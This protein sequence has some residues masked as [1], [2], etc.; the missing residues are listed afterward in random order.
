MG[1]RTDWPTFGATLVVLLGICIP[2][3]VMQEQAN[4]FINAAFSVMT[5]NFG[6]LYQW[7]GI[8]AVGLLLWLAL[9]RFGQVKL[10]NSC[11][12]PE[13]SSFSWAGMLFCAGIGSGI[14]YWGT[15]EWAYYLQTPPLGI[16]ANTD[17]AA[18][19]AA[20]YGMFHWGITAWAFYGVPAIPLAYLY[21]VRKQ[22]ELKLSAAC[23][24]VLGKYAH[25]A[26]GKVIDILFM[27]GLLGGVGT[28]LGL[29]TPMVAAGLSEVFG[30]EN[31]FGLSI[32]V[33]LLCTAIFGV[34]AYSGLKKGIKILS[35]INVWLAI[36]LI[37]FILLV[38]PTLF[39]LK[40]TT[41]SIGLMLQNF[42]QMNFWTDPITNSGF[43]ESWT[44]FYWAWWIAYGPFMGLFVAKISRGRTIRQ[45]ITGMLVY[46][47]LGCWAYFGV[48]GNYAMHLELNDILSVTSILN[49][50]DAPTAI[51]AVIKSLP[52]SSLVL[53][54]FCVLAL[55]FLATQFDSAAYIMAAVATVKLTENEHPARWHVLFWALALAALPLSLMFV[56]GL[57]A[58]QTAA[59]TLALPQLFITAIM[60]ISLVRWLRHDEIN[61]VPSAS[62]VADTSQSFTAANVTATP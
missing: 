4:D 13:F 8:A 45:V 60:A 7:G 19:W 25:G 40:T 58:L 53:P 26:L 6:I 1:V 28:S 14:L 57:K 62:R 41:N 3:L 36:A 50:K 33:M 11:E 30:I 55:I 61:G 47:S 43:T 34:S 29:G 2:L 35:D 54:L 16:T 20:T 24:G 49:E 52:L 56:G 17:K 51:I 15:I 18:E 44:V 39:I 22:P 48:L 21:H 59:I 32:F 10:G 23:E 27:F 42:V 38:G 5:A 9:G 31:S 46:G 37:A 12:R